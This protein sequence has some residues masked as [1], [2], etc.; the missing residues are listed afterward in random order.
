MNG[1]H[2]TSETAAADEGGLDPREA[3]ALLDQTNRQAQRRFETRPPLLMLFA[4]V[5]V[6]VAYGSVWLSVRGQHPYNGPTAAGLIG[7]YSTLTICVVVAAVVYRDA[8]SGVGGQAP[9][10]RRAEGIVLG[11][12]YICV[13]VFG[14]ALHHAGAGRAISY[15]I[16]PAVAPVLIVC[17]ALAARET[18]RENWPWAVF[19]TAAVAVAA[20]AALA[21]PI[22]VWG[23]TGAGLCMLLLCRAA[24]QVWWEPR[25]ARAHGD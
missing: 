16:Y 1:T 15:G 23:V 12:I 4:A 18:A 8:T 22:N 20:V 19:A 25:L 3:A 10:Q 17:A 6:L 11:T 21:G 7:L 2:D 13:Y 9:R 24:V 14:G 5:A